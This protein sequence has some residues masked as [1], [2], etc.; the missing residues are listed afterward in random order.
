M[1]ADKRPSHPGATEFAIVTSRFN[2]LVTERLATAARET[3]IAQGVNTGA[4]HDYFVAGAWELPPAVAVALDS[5]RFRAVIAC[6]AVI[7]GETPHFEHI[8][9]AVTDGL[10]RLQLEHRTPIGFAVLTTDT[11][12]QALERT[13]GK[14]GNKGEE[15]AIAALEAADVLDS[16]KR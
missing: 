1:N 14:A 4:I 11:L 5:G 8:S 16:I 15:A 6:G 3:L 10:A 9:R 13:G 7:R 2:A 12:E